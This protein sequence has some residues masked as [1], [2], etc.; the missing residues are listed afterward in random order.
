MGNSFHMYLRDTSV[1][2]DKHHDI[3]QTACDE[4]TDLINNGI[5]QLP[6]SQGDITN[7]DATSKYNMGAYTDDIN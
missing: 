1:I 7:V 5:D 4:V 6:T 3:L 2:Q